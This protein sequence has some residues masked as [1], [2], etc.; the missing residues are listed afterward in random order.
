MTG[1]C[2]PLQICWFH[3]AF[4]RIWK[5]CL[6]W[7]VRQKRWQRQGWSQV[8]ECLLSQAATFYSWKQMVAGHL[9]LSTW[10]AFQPAMMSLVVPVW[11]G[12]P[13]VAKHFNQLQST[14][15]C[16]SFGWMISIKLFLLIEVLNYTFYRIIKVVRWQQ[17]GSPHFGTELLESP[18]CSTDCDGSASGTCM[19]MRTK[20]KPSFAFKPCYLF[21]IDLVPNLW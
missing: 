6:I 18:Q 17:W 7:V 12:H 14:I 21:L 1:I 16:F 2:I 5:P 9:F 20:D 10:R 19:G 15:I 3:G 13:F 11:W 4:Q 8:L